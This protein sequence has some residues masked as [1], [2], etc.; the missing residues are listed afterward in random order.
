MGKSPVLSDA[1][2]YLS[3]LGLKITGTTLNQKLLYLSQDKENEVNVVHAL[4][5][6]QLITLGWKIANILKI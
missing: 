5:Y 1:V 3:L 2:Y 6:V 4:N